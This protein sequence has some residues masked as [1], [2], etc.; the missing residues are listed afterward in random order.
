MNQLA[1][2]RM[3]RETGGAHQL[4]ADERMGIELSCDNE[5]CGVRYACTVA[6]GIKHHQPH[7]VP[8]NASKL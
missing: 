6:L 5:F 7:D 4:E 2:R 1:G 8:P 3:R